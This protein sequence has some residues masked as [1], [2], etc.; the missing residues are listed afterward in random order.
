MTFNEKFLLIICTSLQKGDFQIIW[1]KLTY[2][3]KVPL[4]RSRGG[5]SRK[6][7]EIFGIRPIIL[8]NLYMPKVKIGITKP[9]FFML[10]A[11]HFSF[12]ISK[13][14]HSKAFHVV[15]TFL[16]KVNLLHF[17]TTSVTS[18]YKLLQIDCN[19]SAKGFREFVT[20]V[21]SKVCRNILKTKYQDK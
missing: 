13:R 15:T 14:K 6:N 18:C 2:I 11:L 20:N 10:Q 1:G 9:P 12:G 5:S 16:E 19:Y 21:T 3:L 4:L 8:N 17:V 7:S